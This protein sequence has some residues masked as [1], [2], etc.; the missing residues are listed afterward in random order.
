[1]K[2]QV[3]LP[4][5]IFVVSLGLVS[6]TIPKNV[7]KKVNKEIRKTFEV[8]AF[9]LEKIEISKEVNSLLVSKIEGEKLFKVV[10]KHELIGY[11]YID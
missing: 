2:K 5:L 6:F 10:A 4:F 8:E 7:Q 9:D 3:L 11:A 1:M